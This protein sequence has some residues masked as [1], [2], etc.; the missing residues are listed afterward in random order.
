MEHTWTCSHLDPKAL[1]DPSKAKACY[2]KSNSTTLVLFEEKFNMEQPVITVPENTFDP[3]VYNFTDTIQSGTLQ[4]KDT[5]TVTLVP[6]RVPLVDML[7]LSAQKPTGD[8]AITFRTNVYTLENTTVT[9]SFIETQGIFS[10]KILIWST[11]K[12][13]F[14][15]RQ[16]NFTPGTAPAD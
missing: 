4:D 8:Q 12:I 9:L 6:G 3:G 5:V 11:K 16:C 13:N 10:S 15:V 7:P 1:N 2:L 14:R